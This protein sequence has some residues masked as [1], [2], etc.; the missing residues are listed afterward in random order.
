MRLE[1]LSSSDA[2]L[3]LDNKREERKAPRNLAIAGRLMKHLFGSMERT[4]R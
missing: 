4:D 2:E 3:G 1:A